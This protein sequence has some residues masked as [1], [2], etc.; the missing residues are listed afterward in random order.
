MKL[1]L[2]LLTFILVCTGCKNDPRIQAAYDLIERVTPGYGEQFKLE[3]MEPIDGMDAY[4]ITS[5]NGKVVLRGNNTISLATAFNQ[6]L[7]YTVM[8]MFPG[9]AI[10]WTCRSNCPCPPPLKTR[11][12]ANTVSI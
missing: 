11:S 9:S 3:L 7:K 6:Y 1:K 12:T 8:H 10:N 2:L 4:E 5:D